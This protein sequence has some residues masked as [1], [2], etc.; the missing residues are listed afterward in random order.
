MGEVRRQA[1]RAADGAED[2][3]D[4]KAFE[5]A[6]RVG[7]AANGL[8]HILIGVIAITV[9]AGGEGEADQSGAI[10]RLGAQPGGI[11]LLWFCFVGLAALALFQLSEAAF[12]WKGLSTK[13]RWAKRIKALGEAVAYAAVGATF[14]VYALG[15][16]ADS[17]GS[18]Q[19]FTAALMVNPAGAAL[20][21]VL[22]AAVIAIGGYSIVRAPLDKM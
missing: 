7:Y 14:G 16:Q 20:L 19:G 9:A 6:A 22:G 5:S 13:D 3:A 10:A 21:I 4:S 11:F 18:A 8:M 12:A 17:G 1:Q 15:G 2:A